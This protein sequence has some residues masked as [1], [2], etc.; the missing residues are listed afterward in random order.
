MLKL[1]VN[2]GARLKPVLATG[3]LSAAVIGQPISGLRVFKSSAEF[4]IAFPSLGVPVV[5]AQLQSGSTNTV[6]LSWGAIVGANTYYWRRVTTATDMIGP[7]TGVTAT[8]ATDAP[9]DG[10]FRYEV[11]ACNS[12][13]CSGYG[14]ST[15]VTVGATALD[16]WSTLTPNLP[17]ASVQDVPLPAFADGILEVGSASGSFRVDES[18]QTSYQ[19]PIATAPATGGMAPEMS[20]S[21]SS[22]SQD[23]YLGVGFQISGLSAITRCRKTVETDALSSPIGVVVN[24]GDDAFCLDGQRLIFERTGNDSFGSYN[25]YSTEIQS[26]ARIRSYQ[27]SGINGPA[28]WASYGKDGALSF[29]GLSNTP[30]ILCQKLCDGRIYRNSNSSVEYTHIT[31]WLISKVRARNSL[32]TTMEFEFSISQENG[33][34]RISKV[35][36]SGADI[37]P[38]SLS[39]YLTFNY[40]APAGR[41]RTVAAMPLT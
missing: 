25:E 3:P 2:P 37:L 27:Q 14:Q 9:G 21:Y 38:N 16:E 39:A 20:I 29:Y 22:G 34:A 6:G 15:N 1:R 36:Y 33:E 35:W 7:D 10:I 40:N 31:A 28:F 19:M 4:T 32:Q 17:L 24:Y 30:G 8:T 5:T 41:A 23:G 11:K 26:F 13:G 12:N 18:G